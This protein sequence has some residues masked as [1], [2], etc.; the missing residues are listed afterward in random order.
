MKWQP[1]ET[2]PRTGK[3]VLMWSRK[4]GFI[5]A[6]WPEGCAPGEW[7]KIGTDWRGSS[8]WRAQEATHWTPLPKA[9]QLE[10]S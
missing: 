9:P 10:Q 5:A 1:I 2:A 8:H 3:M 4:A 7:L 6:N